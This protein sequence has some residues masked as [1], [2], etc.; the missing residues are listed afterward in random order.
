MIH[1]LSVQVA[2]LGHLRTNGIESR[3]VEKCKV[4]KFEEGGG[5]ALAIIS[6]SV[7]EFF[8]NNN[9]EL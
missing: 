2:L 9:G 4:W 6:V 3:R 5:G 7:K 8:L 1:Q